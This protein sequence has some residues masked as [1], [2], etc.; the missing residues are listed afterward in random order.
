MSE[1]PSRWL[2]CGELRLL[3]ALAG[4]SALVS[5]LRTAQLLTDQSI[6]GHLQF[7]SSPTPGKR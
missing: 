4:P 7:E 5:S 6:L 3:L 2:S 1:G